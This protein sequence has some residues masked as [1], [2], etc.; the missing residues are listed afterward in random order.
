MSVF[1]RLH[2]MRSHAC[3]NLVHDR[4]AIGKPRGKISPIRAIIGCPQTL[5]FKGLAACRVLLDLGSEG[6]SPARLSVSARITLT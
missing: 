4:Q 3:M 6:I 1:F 5:I 2:F